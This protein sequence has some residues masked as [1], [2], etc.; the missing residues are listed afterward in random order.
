MYYC[1]YSQ[2]RAPSKKTG[3]LREAG[4]IMWERVP[5][6]IDRLISM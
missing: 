6:T 2:Y 4:F 1:V 3:M 5:S